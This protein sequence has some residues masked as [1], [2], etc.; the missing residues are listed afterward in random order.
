MNGKSSMMEILSSIPF[1]QLLFAQNTIIHQQDV[2]WDSETVELEEH[3]L[4]VRDGFIV[5]KKIDWKKDGF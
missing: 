4:E 2:E 1:E 3:E 5:P